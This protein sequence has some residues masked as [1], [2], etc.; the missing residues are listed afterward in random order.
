MDGRTDGQSSTNYRRYAS[1]A[2]TVATSRSPSRFVRADAEKLTDGL[3][4]RQT[5]LCFYYSMSKA[6]VFSCRKI[7]DRQTMA[8]QKKIQ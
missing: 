6:N 2:T 7:F 1:S 8:N 5:H 3:A 4:E